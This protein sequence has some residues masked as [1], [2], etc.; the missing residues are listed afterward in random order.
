MLGGKAGQDQVWEIQERNPE[1]QE[2]EWKHAA[3]GGG[4]GANTLESPRDM[5]YERLS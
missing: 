3:S 4:S 2:N 1:G 5:G